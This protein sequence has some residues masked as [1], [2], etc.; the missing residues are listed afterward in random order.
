M[1]QDSRRGGGPVGVLALDKAGNLY[2][3]TEIGGGI[4]DQ[5]TVFGTVVKL[6]KTGKLTVLYSFAGGADGAFPK[7]TL[8]QDPTGALYGVTIFGG[9][10]SC[11]STC[12]VV[13]KVDPNGKETPAQMFQ[14]LLRV[15]SPSLAA[16]SM[17]AKDEARVWEG[18]WRGV[19]RSHCEWR[20]T[21]IFRL[22][23]LRCRVF[24]RQRV[25]DSACTDLNS[26]CYNSVT[27]HGQMLWVVGSCN[28]ISA[29][30]SCRFP[31]Y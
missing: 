13:Y 26:V 29:A 21:R 31:V 27:A 14:A 6:D 15:A 30:A 4:G 12:G 16:P 1:A 3:T 25:W 7:G 18:L 19:S 28:G 20:S 2:D 24:L 11:G 23:F 8:L 17:R 5:D 22:P 9:A 10:P